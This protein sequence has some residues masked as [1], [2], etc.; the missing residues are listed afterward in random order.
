MLGR[1]GS[2]FQADSRT[3]ARVRSV[4]DASAYSKVEV[5]P[6]LHYCSC[7]QFHPPYSDL[8]SSLWGRSILQSLLCTPP[9]RSQTARSVHVSILF[10]INEGESDIRSPC[11]PSAGG[12]LAITA[13]TSQTP[14][15]QTS[16]TSHVAGRHVTGSCAPSVGSVTV[17]ERPEEAAVLLGLRQ[18]G[19]TVCNTWSL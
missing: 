10:G 19:D 5:K 18:N 1:E 16:L 13:H 4:V 11:P 3:L 14:L 17:A 15:S 9:A 6:S 12:G 7:R 2:Q 8:P